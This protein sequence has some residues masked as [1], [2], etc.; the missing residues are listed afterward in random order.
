MILLVAFSLLLCDIDGMVHGG[1]SIGGI[2]L[3]RHYRAERTSYLELYLVTLNKPGPFDISHSTHVLFLEH[4]ILSFLKD[5]RGGHLSRLPVATNFC[6]LPLPPSLLLQNQRRHS[7]PS[8]IFWAFQT[9]SCHSGLCK[10]MPP[11]AF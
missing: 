3:E 9:S 1:G 11:P 7:H 10:Y 5:L 2:S 8:A 6:S 4:L